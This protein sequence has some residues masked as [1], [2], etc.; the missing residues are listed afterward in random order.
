MSEETSPNAADPASPA[1]QPDEGQGQGEPPVVVEESP[2]TA[3]QVAEWKQGA[4]DYAEANKKITEQGQQISGLTEQNRQFEVWYAR[5]E[6]EAEAAKTAADPLGQLREQAANALLTGD[7]A[8]YSAAQAQVDAANREQ[9]RADARQDQLAN[10]SQMLNVMK[11]REIAN[12]YGVTDDELAASA[13]ALGATAITPE[14]AEFTA[15]RV[16]KFQPAKDAQA[17]RKDQEAKMAAML[18]SGA[19][20]G[21]KGPT[22]MGLEPD[23]PLEEYNPFRVVYFTDANNNFKKGQEAEGKAYLAKCDPASIPP[24]MQHLL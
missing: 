1:V 18:G 14:L 24:H 16:G 19:Q 23:A 12:Q 3:E 6:A 17:K 4:E 22:R 20:G 2:P 7:A 10:N 13:R 9:S 5:K 8:A 11:V 21:G 15:Q